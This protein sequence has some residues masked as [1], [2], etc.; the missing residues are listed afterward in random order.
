MISLALD[1]ATDRCT[2]AAGAGPQVAHRFLDGSRRHA[3]T[4]LGLIDA[5][6]A[7][8]GI[9]VTDVQRVIIADG[10]GSFTGLRV[11][12][13]VAKALAW[14]SG[15]EVRAAPSLLVRA[16][17]HAPADGGTVLALSDALRGELYA[18][19]WRI[20]GT[21]VTLTSSA[22]RAITVAALSAYLPVDVIV[23]SVP[24]ALVADVTRIAGRAP[25]SGEA[26]L[27]DAR[28]LL[29]LAELPGGT[30]AVTDPATW[31]PEY[32]RPSEAQVVW[33]RVHGTELPTAAS[34]AS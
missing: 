8:L 33:E 32:G 34:H 24:D 12:A 7:E 21:G 20:A 22:P 10:P 29:K 19:S 14:R 2:I 27:P 4:I 13:S 17:A 6:F 26:A 23:G 3:S 15:V 30:I 5:V 25:V 1:T 31:Q 9:S 16:A 11:A 18:A 28:M